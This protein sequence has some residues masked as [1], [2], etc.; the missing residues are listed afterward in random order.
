MDLSKPQIDPSEMPP[1][2]ITF[3]SEE[4]GIKL[5]QICVETAKKTGFSSGQGLFCTSAECFDQN[6]NTN[7]MGNRKRAK[8]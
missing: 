3:K 8:K 1:F 7:L 5:R 4:L 6:Q 2:K